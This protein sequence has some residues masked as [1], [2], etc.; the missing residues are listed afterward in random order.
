MRC[1]ELVESYWQ[2]PTSCSGIGWKVAGTLA[3][4]EDQQGTGSDKDRSSWQD[5]GQFHSSRTSVQPCEHHM[6]RV[7]GLVDQISEV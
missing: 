1:T 5:Q 7:E 6:R 4:V 2:E 3:A